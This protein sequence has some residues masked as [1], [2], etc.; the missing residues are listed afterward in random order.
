MKNVVLYTDGGA[1]GNPGPGGWGALLIY[2]E[3]RKELSGGFCLT[4]NN[5]MELTAVV[6]G[7][8]AIKYPCDVTVYSDSRYVVDGIEKGWARRWRINGWTRNKKREPAI[9]ADLWSELL[10]QTE[11]HKVRLRWVKGHAGQPENERCDELAVNASHVS[12][13]PDDPG[14]PE[15][16]LPAGVSLFQLPA[17]GS[18]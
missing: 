2:G 16:L 15:P 17:P 13:L 11:R 5:R 4:T 6:E 18:G 12:G 7:L 3:H 10:N 1:R 9:N 8:R 14:Y